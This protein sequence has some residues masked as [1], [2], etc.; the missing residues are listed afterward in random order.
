MI[1][2]L[3]LFGL[4]RSLG[5]RM[6]RQAP[7]KGNQTSLRISL[8]L[9]AFA[10]SPYAQDENGQS[11]FRRYSPGRCLEIGS[12]PARPA[13]LVDTVLRLAD[14]SAIFHTL[15]GVV[16]VPTSFA[17]QCSSHKWIW[18]A[19]CSFRSQGC[20]SPGLQLRLPPSTF[21]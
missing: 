1:G 13:Q 11:N 5:K 14:V 18:W 8:P 16:Y 3:I 20:T 4:D 9:E 15:R 21:R 10:T 6:N 17:T 12:P 19:L 7:T 2:A